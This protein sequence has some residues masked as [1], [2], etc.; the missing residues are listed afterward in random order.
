MAQILEDSYTISLFFCVIVCKGN[1]PPLA[2]QALCRR[3][4]SS[5]KQQ[6]YYNMK[7]RFFIIFFTIFTLAATSLIVIQIIQTKQSVSISDNLFNIS[8]NNA[9]D[10]I[11]A[12]FDQMKVEDYVSQ[13]DRSKIQKYRRL[14]E[15][16]TKLLDLV[17]DHADLFYDD[18]R[19]SFGVSMQDSAY[20]IPHTYISSSDSNIIKQYNTLLHARQRLTN[21]GNN[22]KILSSTLSDLA[23]G[24]VLNT[25]KFNY[26]MLDS[27]I[28]EELVINGVDIPPHIGVLNYSTDEFIYISSPDKKKDLRES[29]YKYSFRPGAMPSSDEYYI[30]LHFPSAALFIQTHTGL[31]VGM[32]IFLITIIIILF[33]I[34]ARIIF[35][36]RK[37]D[38]MKTDFINNMTHEIKTP[39]AT[40]GL[41]CEMLKDDSVKSDEATRHNFINIIDDENRRMR[42]L[43]ETILQ[44]AKMANKNFSI[45][46][47]EL[48]I[49]KV[50]RDTANSFQL[51]LKNRNGV[52][53]TDLH[54]AP[55]QIYADELHITNVIHNMIDNAIK[56]SPD[57]PHIRVSSS[58]SDG[59]AKISIQD[60][61]IGIAKEDQKHIFEKF[62]RVSTG[63]VHNV[64][65]FGI[66]LNYVAQ[67]IAL[68][69]GK[70]SVESDLGKGS[71]FT[72]ILPLA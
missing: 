5:G 23:S 6:L 67:V 48:D 31:Y 13:K 52:I 32:S 19:V 16:N 49:D 15:L 2:R 40:I 12:Q 21:E 53:D 39:I 70:V 43:I 44:S 41:A 63:D 27:L 61:G 57:N 10:N 62:Y 56:Y 65:G 64:K 29:P 37:V 25:D 69:H 33:L 58:I 28:R 11:I 47:S 1:H 35:N 22:D 7:R 60:H 55:S 4:G 68:H 24:K 50:I 3:A 34:S 45:Q 9:M 66:G 38:L 72:I 18:N 46:C 8:V 59:M 17:R 14:E 51:S 26:H 20:T 54:V 42:V 36:Q 71:T 30:V